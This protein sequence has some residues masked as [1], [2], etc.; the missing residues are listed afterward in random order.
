M[1][2]VALTDLKL[3]VIEVVDAVYLLHVTARLY[4]IASGIIMHILY[5]KECEI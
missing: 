5:K 3:L 1:T 4:I 2:S